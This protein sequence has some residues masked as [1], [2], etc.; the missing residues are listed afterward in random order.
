MSTLKASLNPPPSHPAADP[1]DEWGSRQLHA[2]L[3][4]CAF[5]FAPTSS[6][7]SL[8][9]R[10][11]SQL[12]TLFWVKG[13]VSNVPCSQQQL[14][15]DLAIIPHKGGA[16]AAPSCFAFLL[17]VPIHEAAEVLAAAFCVWV[18]FLV[19][20]HGGWGWTHNEYH[21]TASNWSPL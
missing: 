11:H 1:R 10:A 21:K 4:K 14:L 16:T 8:L 20:L 18:L 3:P 6:S 9:H 19:R 15:L 7:T 17:F 2:A 12:Q 13:A 5:C